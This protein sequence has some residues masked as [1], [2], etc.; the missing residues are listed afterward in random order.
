MK[1]TTITIDDDLAAR[2]E[3]EQ[4]RQGNTASGVIREALEAYLASGRE[5]RRLGFAKLG[6]TETGE[7]VGRNAEAILA[8]EY[9][10]DIAR[11]NGI[12]LPIDQQQ[13]PELASAGRFSAHDNS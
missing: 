9:A 4:R 10:T 8:A 5:P 6:K 3:R 1:R 12:A 2:L 13:E 11:R 7:A